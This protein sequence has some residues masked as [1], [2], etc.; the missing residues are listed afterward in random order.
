MLVC[1]HVLGVMYV[2]PSQSVALSV[3][4]FILHHWKTNHLQAPG[5]AVINVDEDPLPHHLLHLSFLFQVFLLNDHHDYLFVLQ[6]LMQIA[7]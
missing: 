2:L 3:G 6:Y 4:E 1:G 5:A 7:M